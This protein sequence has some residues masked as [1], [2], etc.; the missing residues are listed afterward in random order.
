M[1]RIYFAALTILLAFPLAAETQDPSGFTGTWKMD[2]ARSESAH[3]A[4][5]IG[6]VTL[7]VRQTGANLSIQTV[8]G[9]PK[10][11]KTQSET[12]TFKLDGSESV[13]ADNSGNPIKCKARWDGPKLVTETARN[14]QDASVTTIYVYTLDSQ[15]K[16][17]T[18]L[19]TLTVQHGYQFEGAKN[20]GTGTDVF[21]R[22]KG[23]V[24]K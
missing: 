6:P 10:S 2:A 9:D 16:E 20:T 13:T 17:M 8:R 7:I 21:V 14:I 24:P 22:A 18:V 19:K 1:P 12:L 3:Q 11:P 5:P 15:G 4:V 23:A